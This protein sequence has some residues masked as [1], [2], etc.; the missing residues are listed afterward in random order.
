MNKIPNYIQIETV[1]KCNL[2]CIICPR[3]KFYNKEDKNKEMDFESFKK[4]I[5]NSPNLEYVDL[6]GVGEC[7]L[8]KDFIKILKYAKDKGLKIIF[9]DN[10]TMMNEN[11]IN[12]LINLKV[13]LIFCSIDGA[14][15]NTFEGIRKGAKF[16]DVINNIKKFFEIKQKKNVKLPQIYFYYVVNRYNLDEIIKFINLV[17]EISNDTKIIFSKGVDLTIEI[18]KIPS[19]I[20]KE[21]K[22]RANIFNIPLIWWNFD[23]KPIKKC[24]KWL[25]P[26]VTFDGKVWPCCYS[27]HVSRYLMKKN[28]LGNLLK[29]SFLDIW[30]N[31]K[32]QEF[33]KNIINNKKP[34]LCKYCLLFY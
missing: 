31:R 27:T 20:I 6:T 14:T 1:T 10:F 32:Y 4:I 18:E 8:N 19:Q 15:K 17:N 21:A 28:Y 11:W 12:K 5:D 25:K 30:E 22:I 9:F 7:L 33:R 24:E 34:L 26:Y 23:K 3:T 2:K 29:E 13:D 16:E